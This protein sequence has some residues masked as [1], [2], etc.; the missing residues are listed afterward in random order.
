MSFSHSSKSDYTSLG[1]KSDGI[2]VH[3]A[4]VQ[5][6][7]KEILTGTGVSSSQFWALMNSVI[8]KFTKTNYD[9]LKFRDSLQLSID[10]W[11][12]SGR[13]TDQVSFLK[14][15]GYLVPQPTCEEISISTSHVDPEISQVAAPQLVVPVD[16]DRFVV[17]AV[18]SRWGSLSAAVSSSDVLGKNPTKTAIHEYLMTFLDQSVP[19]LSPESSW[20]DVE[21]ICAHRLGGSRGGFLKIVLKDGGAISGLRN[22]DN[23]AGWSLNSV[24]LKHHGLHIWIQTNPLG[25][26][27]DVILESSLTAILD[28]ED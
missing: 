8:Q 7:E 17:N 16:N 25:K 5:C 9:L 24:F 20:K 15:I 27:L 12:R 28:L 1:L 4:L 19:L 13:P 10:D 14:N 3:N 6:I 23:W 11:Y 2:Q 21:S 18:N 26:I 22:H